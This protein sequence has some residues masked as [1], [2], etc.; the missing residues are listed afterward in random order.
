M[1][2]GKTHPEAELEREVELLKA[3]ERNLSELSRSTIPIIQHASMRAHAIIRDL[4]VALGE[5]EP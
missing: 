2:A 4:L 1:P 5:M 3:T